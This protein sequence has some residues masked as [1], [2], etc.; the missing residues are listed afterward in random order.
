[1]PVTPRVSRQNTC[2][3]TCASCRRTWRSSSPPS[4]SAIPSRARSSAWARP[5]IP[6]LPDLGDIDIR[7][8]VP[9]YRV[10]KDGKLIDEPLDIRK[11]WSEELVTFVLGLLVLLRT[12]DLAGRHPLCA[13]SRMTPPCRCIAPASTACRQDASGA[14]WWC[15]CAPFTPGRCHSV[16]SRSP[17]G[18]RPCM[19]RRCTSAMPEAIGI[20]DIMRPD[21]GDPRDNARGRAAAVLGLRRHAAGRHRGGATLA[22]ASRT[23]PVLDADHR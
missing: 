9:R 23:S 18:F 8:D 15:R 21:F 22:S 10:F 6:P 12:A 19:V 2:R 7:T 1:M 4:A 16:S 14:R 5:A 17:R 13:T 11:Y 20:R 3:A